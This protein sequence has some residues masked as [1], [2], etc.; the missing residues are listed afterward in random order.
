MI[1]FF[2]TTT[3][4]EGNMNLD[5]QQSR[6]DAEPDYFMY[7]SAFMLAFWPVTL[8]LGLIDYLFIPGYDLRLVDLMIGL[9]AGW[10]SV[11][12]YRS[13]EEGKFAS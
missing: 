12:I 13:R 6:D 9:L 4:K 11:S 10:V 2:M 8:I 1:A 3:R 5:H 7:F